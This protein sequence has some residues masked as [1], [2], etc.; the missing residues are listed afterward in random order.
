MWLHIWARLRPVLV[1]PRVAATEVAEVS[2]ELDEVPAGAFGLDAGSALS[3]S[4]L[5][6]R[7]RLRPAALVEEL[8]AVLEEQL[9]VLLARRAAV[10]VSRVDDV[11]E[12]Q[13]FE[14]FPQV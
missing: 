12:P 2:A 1:R 9:E 8:Q 5:F 13:L 11:L 14:A 4:C 6:G 7:P 3:M 10:R